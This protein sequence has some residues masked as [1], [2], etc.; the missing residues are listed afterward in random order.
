M[1]SQAEVLDAWT[2]AVTAL[3]VAGK[4][5][6]ISTRF[7]KD[8]EKLRGEVLAMYEQ[9]WLFARAIDAV[10][11][12]GTQKW[13]RI[14]ARS[15]EGKVMRPRWGSVI[16]DGLERLKAR[17][18]FE[19]AWK[20]DRLDGGSYMIIGTNG[21]KDKLEEELTVSNVKSVDFLN[22]VSRYDVNPFANSIVR[23]PTKFNYLKPEIYSLAGSTIKVHASR[24]LRFDGI[25]RPSTASEFVE[26]GISITSRI[27]DAVR[28]FGEAFGYFSG[29]FKQMVQG[30][31]RMKGLANMMAADED[32]T[33]LLVK[34]LAAMALA[35]SAFNK[36]LL[37]EDESYENAEIDFTGAGQAILRV[38][39]LV[40]GA[41]ETPLSILFGQAPTGMS[42]DDESGRRAFYSMVARQQGAKLR[43]PLR[44]LVE[45][46]MKTEKL[47][48]DYDP[49]TIVTLD[50]VPLDE[51]TAKERAEINKTDADAD[52][53]LVR[54]GI[55]TEKE[56][57]TRISKDPQ[58]PYDLDED[59]E[60]TI[61]PNLDPTLDPNTDP[62]SHLN[63]GN[64]PG[65][66]QDI[67]A[68][69]PNG[70]QL[71]AQWTV[72]KDVAQ[73]LAPRES[74]AS[75]MT[76]NFGLS[77]QQANALLGP[78]GFEPKAPPP[79]PFNPGG[80]PPQPGE[81]QPPPVPPQPKP[82][83]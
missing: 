73:G 20:M 25:R 56:A 68:T 22:V 32:A 15:P 47:G 75:F 8:D 81:K 35:A 58:S 54:E 76:I 51:P 12:Y 61:D 59:F 7:E 46:L 19:H 52:S 11:E 27:Y 79:S 78:V 40:A 10:P 48:E 3:G 2:N 41:S 66:A 65:V 9:D 71:N 72:I 50:F 53:E 24:V 33:N 30:I 21:G 16:S 57:R 23:D 6:Q 64:K 34:R 28:K 5:A 37:D 39:D 62:T 45:L 44:W 38:M 69:L 18:R 42:T 49:D 17:D 14:G 1:A 4:D 31:L 55:V 13:I 43:A 26:A 29:S 74:G 70:T 80:G 67:Q 36:I 83:V 63:D 77:P 60:P 82:G